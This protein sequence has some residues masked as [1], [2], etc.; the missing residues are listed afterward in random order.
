MKPYWLDE[1]NTTTERI[2]KARERV[3]YLKQSL[4]ACRPIEKRIVLVNLE[5]A[6]EKLDKEMACI[7]Q[8]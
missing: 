5:K 6:I 3:D 4:Y 2:E 8:M 1:C 7:P